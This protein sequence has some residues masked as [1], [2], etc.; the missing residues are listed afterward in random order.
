MDVG[1][2][3]LSVGPVQEQSWKAWTVPRTSSRGFERERDLLRLAGRNG[4]ALR[5]H[6]VL[7]VPGLHLK[8]P[9]GQIPQ[10][11]V[12]LRVRDAKKG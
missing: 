1:R 9:G 8:R 11:H 5:P 2:L 10:L 4:H 12:S 3:I 6:S 7:F